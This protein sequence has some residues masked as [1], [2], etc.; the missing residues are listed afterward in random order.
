MENDVQI[1]LSDLEK[2]RALL[3]QK[4]DEINSL[5]KELKRKKKLNYA[6]QVVFGTNPERLKIM[7]QGMK[8]GNIPEM[9]TEQERHFQK[10]AAPVQEAL[11]NLAENRNKKVKEE[12]NQSD[13]G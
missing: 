5:K 4:N 1:I 10:G 7:L 9:K 12:E 13:S 11:K 6:Y 3:N 8:L 2:S